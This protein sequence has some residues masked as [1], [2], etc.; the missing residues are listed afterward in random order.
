MKEKIRPQG[1]IEVSPIAIA[2]LAHKAVIRSYGIVGTVPKDLPTGIANVLSSESR[3][4][5]VVRVKDGQIYI[6]LY[7][8]IEYGTRIA[9]VARSAMNVVKYTVEKNLGV[10]VAEVNV[11]VEGLR[12]SD[13]D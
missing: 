7:V 12:I 11:H 10:P 6:D 9:S 13:P 1:R 5:V 8:I 2:S 4:G 3:R